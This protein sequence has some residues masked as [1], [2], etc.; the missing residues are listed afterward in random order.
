MLKWLQTVVIRVRVTMVNCYVRKNIVHMTFA[1]FSVVSC[2]TLYF[3]H[4]PFRDAFKQVAE[5]MG[6]RENSHRIYTHARTHA[7]NLE[8]SGK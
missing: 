3:L 1:D 4:Y 6:I 5:P 7:H 2:F 8:I